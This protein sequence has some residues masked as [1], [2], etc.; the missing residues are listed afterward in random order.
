MSD[1]ASHL[2]EHRKHIAYL[3]TSWRIN[4][5]TQGNSFLVLLLQNGKVRKRLRIYFLI[6][7]VLS[8]FAAEGKLCSVECSSVP[9]W[10]LT[11]PGKPE[12]VFSVVDFRHGLGIARSSYPI[13]VTSCLKF[14]CLR[15]RSKAQV[16][17]YCPCLTVEPNL[18]GLLKLQL[19]Q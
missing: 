2:E 16:W 10:L 15:R 18:S 19:V 13:L 1:L 4:K 6:I 11:W 3:P 9:C 5:S 7:P 12:A 17:G 14:W 8:C